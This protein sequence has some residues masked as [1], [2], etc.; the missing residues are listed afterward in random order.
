[1]FG[2]LFLGALSWGSIFVALLRYPIP[3][4]MGLYCSGVALR[5]GW[6]PIETFATGM[7]ACAATHAVLLAALE[8]RNVVI[9]SSAVLLMGSASIWVGAQGL[10]SAQLLLR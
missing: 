7:L 2:A 10:G 4:A 3:L 8:T 1:M 6:G 5:S 9:R